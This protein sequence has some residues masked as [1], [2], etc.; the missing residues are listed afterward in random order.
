MFSQGSYNLQSGQGPQTPRP[1]PFLQHPP[2]LLPLPQNF[3]QGPLLPLPQV[4]PRPGQP[5]LPIYQQG[6]LA[7][8]LAVR[9]VQP[10]LPNTGQPYFPPPPAVHG[11][12][13]LPHVYTTAPPNPQGS[14]H[15]SYLA[16]GLPPPP[17]AAAA[18]SHNLEMLQVTLPPRS[19]PPTPSQGQTLY[20]APIHQLPQQP[21]GMQGLQQIPPPPPPPPTFSTSSLSGNILEAT[22]GNSQMS[23]MVPP[24]TSPPPPLP[25]SSPPPIPPSS[26]PPV[27]S[28]PSVSLPLPAG[29]NMP[30]G[31]N[32][33]LGTLGPVTEVRPLNRAEHSISVQKFSVDDGS[34][35]LEGQ[36]GNELNYPG[37]D[38]LSL[39]GIV[40]SDVP[41]PPKPA[42]EKIVQKIEEFCQ[43][44]A[45]NGSSYEDIARLKGSENPEFKFLFGGEP[46]SEAAI[47]HEYFLWMKKQC[48]LASKSDGIQPEM[49]TNHLMLTTEIHSPADSDMEMEDDITR[50]DVD[51]A[52]NQPIENPTQAIGPISSEFD[53]KKQLHKLLSSAGSGAG[54]MVLSERQGEEGSKLVS[55]HDDLTFGRSVFRVESPVI[56][57]TGATE[58]PFASNRVESSTVLAVDN[59]SSKVAAAAECMNSDSYSGQVMKGS[60]PFRLLQDYASNDSSENDEDSHFKDAN[61]ETV[62]SLVAVS[63][64]GFGMLSESGMLYKA[65]E[66]SSYSQRGVKETVPISIA[67]GPSTKLID[68]KLEN[69]SSIDH[70]TCHEALPKED[71]SGGAGANVASSGKYEDSKDKNAKLEGE[72]KNAK[73]TSNA[74]KID[75]FGRLVREGVSDSDSED[76]HHAYRRNKRGRSRSRSPLDRRRRNH[77]PRRRREKRSR[78]RGWSPRNRRSRSRS[79]SFRHAGEFSG[80]NRRLEKG[81]LPDCFNF[82]RGRCY[83]GASCRY[84][85]HDFEKINGSRHHKSKQQEVQLPPS[86]KNCNTHE[87]NNVVHNGEDSVGDALVDSEI[88]KSD[89]FR[90]IVAELP[91]TRV[92]EERSEDGTTCVGEN[93]QE[94][95]ESDQPMVVDSFPSKRASDANLMKSHG[96]TPQDVISSLKIQQSQSVQSD[97]VLE[98]A[99][100]HAQQTD[101]SSISDTSPNKT[102]RTSP[103]KLHGTETLPNSADSVH[104]PSQM[105]P[106]PS[107][108]PNAEGN[109][110]SHMAQLSRDCNLMPQTAAFQSQSVP[111]ENFPSYMLP[112]HILFFLYH[113]IPH[114]PRCH[115][116]HHYCHHMDQLEMQALQNQVLLRNF[117]RFP[118][119]QGGTLVLKCS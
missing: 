28:S 116:H 30:C 64:R 10:G 70:A 92:V 33:Q 106:V 77:H 113:Q 22:V 27:F 29:F 81:Q 94:A 57:P 20:R 85:H 105:P 49:S 37:G 65:L 61:P 78:S 67:T 35:F 112:N 118:C 9:Q 12:T 14:Q 107:S 82:L 4:L 48:L 115:R 6:P 5:G 90:Q 59:S 80:G 111:S 66:S 52:V 110:T 31:S 26:P 69:Q 45:K 103:K 44:I 1:P 13:R 75:K 60:S 72:D 109:N 11:S 8:H 23:S 21:G 89:S 100:N 50:S 99:D 41:C 39:N 93:F 47:A 96:E 18:G 102:S 43:L 87:D 104:N 117:S 91:K 98:D 108:A 24:S 25:S 62:S 97:P 34:L 2:A 51:Q 74:Q 83:R 53:A 56:N 15:S 19:L 40:A 36:S 84:M 114:L 46:S 58:Y 38:G 73:F 79:P 7:P 17:P 42:E 55:S 68:I 54:T 86:S 76:S 3:Q 88:I 63:E 101:D 95:M 71:A 32:P 119:L 16:P